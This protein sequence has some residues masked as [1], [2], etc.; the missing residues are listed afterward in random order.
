MERLKLP[1]L[2]DFEIEA[3]KLLD[4]GNIKNKTIAEVADTA[5]IVKEKIDDLL[6]EAYDNHT[7]LPDFF[8]GS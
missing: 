3:K 4:D 7:I 1:K 6:E 2:Y 8:L 5:K